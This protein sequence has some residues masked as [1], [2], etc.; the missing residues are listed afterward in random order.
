MKKYFNFALLS[1][2]ALTGTIGFTAC[3][4][5]DDSVA[6]NSKVEVNPTYDPVANTVTAQFVLNVASGD[7]NSTRQSASIVQ[8]NSNFRGMQDAKLIALSTGKSAYLAPFN[9][10]ATASFAVNKTFD[11]G[12]LYGSSAVNSS[13]NETSSSNRIL[14]L[15]MP[16]Q[17]DAMLVTIM[18]RYFPPY[19]IKLGNLATIFTHCFQVILFNVVV[20]EIIFR[21]FI[22]VRNNCNT[23][24]N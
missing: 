7:M 6:E 10:E 9:G 24:E 13:N 20:V 11:L 19:L 21:Y 18:H 16:L 3:S 23:A 4:S 8:K 17:S 1:A 22:C 12:T 2:I 14:E 15:A 5:S